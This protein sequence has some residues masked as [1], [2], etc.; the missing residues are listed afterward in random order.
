MS[1]LD[2]V[3]AKTGSGW[4]ECETC[5]RYGWDLM[6]GWAWGLMGGT[7]WAGWGVEGRKNSKE[8]LG[9]TERCH[10]C[11]ALTMPSVFVD[12]SIRL[13]LSRRT[14]DHRN[15]APYRER[16][17]KPKNTRISYRR[18]NKERIITDRPTSSMQRSQ[19]STRKDTQ[20]AQRPAAGKPQS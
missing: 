6:C 10:Y 7:T 12:A 9:D 13:C 19:N 8:A 17:V 4:G 18:C 14:C 1:G 5:L 20:L 11:L 2:R 16:T 3:R 15:Q